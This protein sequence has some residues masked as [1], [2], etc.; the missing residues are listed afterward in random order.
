V[1]CYRYF[2]ESENR[3]D[4]M[5]KIIIFGGAGFIGSHVADVLVD[6]GYEVTVFDLE[7]NL[8]S[9]KKQHFIKGDILDIENVIATV[10]KND[11]VYNFAGEANLEMSAKDPLKTI[12][13]NVIGNTNILEACRKNEVER[14]VYASTVYVYSNAGSF[15]RSS[16]QACESIIEDYHKEFDLDFTIM[17]YGTLYGPRSNENNWIYSVLKQAIE[18]NLI[19]REGNGEEIREY[20]HVHDAARLSVKVLD[21]KYKNECVM[22]TGNNQIRIKDVMTMIREMLNNKVELKFVEPE[23]DLHYQITPYNFSPKLA[24]KMVDEHYI[25]LGQGIL[26]MINRMYKKSKLK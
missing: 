17:R 11:I 7:E 2:L 5:K 14:F 23:R 10:A 22:I 16:K 12:T 19:I 26:D 20:V 15:Y 21:D 24:K 13:S 9:G 18:K 3:K 8:Y 1:Y 4:N 25:D 6:Q